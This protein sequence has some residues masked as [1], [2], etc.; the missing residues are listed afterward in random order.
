LLWSVNSV[1]PSAAIANFLADTLAVTWPVLD[2][3]APRMVFLA[4]IYAILAV[5][6]I[7]ATRWGARL[8]VATAIVKLTPLVLLVV[9][10]IFSIRAP[11]LRWAGLPE[12]KT[13]GQGCVLL[14]FVFMGVEGGLTAS[15]EVK[16]PAR[17]VPR[18]V[19]LAFVLICSL[20]I[21]L[22]LV[23]QGVLGADL[24]SAKAPLAATAAAVFGP[25]GGR[26]MIAAAVLSAAGYLTGDLLCSPR[27]LYAM[28]EAGQLPRKLAVIHPRFGTP[29]VALVVYSLICFIVAISGSFRQL[30]IVSSS[31]TLLLYLICCI[32]L[33]RLRA[34]NVAMEGE[35][36][37]APGGVF[38]PLLA[39]AIMI[40]ML[41]TLEWKELVAAAGL[42]I[43][44]GVAYWISTRQRN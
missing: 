11:N 13:I 20:Y 23:A 22:Q 44:S 12:L 15:G 40:W 8:S 38:V 36:F 24:A 16:D 14:F 42:V 39:S 43:V 18:A 1:F 37:R 30:V 9:A 41:T 6:N 4:A 3:T 29:V 10:G 28:A 26:C 21:G 32:G 27:S 34:R 19:G 2:K 7:R 33:L 31:G 25:W 5:A 17:A 35:P